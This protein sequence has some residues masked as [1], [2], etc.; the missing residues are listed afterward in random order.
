[1]NYPVNKILTNNCVFPKHVI[2]C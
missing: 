1:M 2:V